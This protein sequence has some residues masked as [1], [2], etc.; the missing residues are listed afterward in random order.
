[1]KTI[2]TLGILCLMIISASC[3]ELDELTEFD[4]SFTLSESV[5]ISVEDGEEVQTFSQSVSLDLSEDQDVA[6]NLNAIEEVSI[7]SLT[8]SYMDVMG[9]EEAQI[10]NAQFTV[11]GTSIEIEDVSPA[12]AQGATFTISDPSALNSIAS[13]LQN[14]PQT[15]ISYTAEVLGAPVSFTLAIDVEVTV[16]IDPI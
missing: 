1:M 6:D 9:N 16:T 8:Y 3:D 4:T 13:A 14:N 2:K 5:L 15:T 7:Q 11:A 12:D 10:E